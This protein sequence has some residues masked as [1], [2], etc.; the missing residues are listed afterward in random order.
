MRWGLTPRWA[1]RAT[2]S[3]RPIINA[4]AE[5]I[6]E[7]PTFRDALPP[8]RHADSGCLGSHFCLRRLA[9]SRRPAVLSR[10]SGPSAS[11]YV[12]AQCCPLAC[13]RVGAGAPGRALQN[14]HRRPYVL[15]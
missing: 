6:A 4:R 8:A 12:G 7:K 3:S 15:V 5:T 1:K 13:W 2:G 11:C 14:D 9:P 10:Q